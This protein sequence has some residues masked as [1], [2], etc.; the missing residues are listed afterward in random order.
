MSDTY[1]YD[2]L[3]VLADGAAA[4]TTAGI[5]QAASANRILDLGGV[6][7]RT[8]LGIV[9]GWAKTLAMCV[10]DVSA[11]VVST[12][13][14]YSID[15]M[16]SNNSDGSDPVHL[17]GLKLGFSAAIPNGGAGL[18]VDGTGS[19]T[20]VGRFYLPVHTAQNK[21]N[22]RYVYIYNTLSGTAESITYTAF[23]SMWP[24]Q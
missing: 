7:N 20:A 23:L 15:I 6:P 4:T 12:D 10:I 14:A 16:G 24:E 18:A 21:I 17:C 1:Q 5:G 19:T 2:A 8:D 22:Y 11:I 13:E 9:G 3:L